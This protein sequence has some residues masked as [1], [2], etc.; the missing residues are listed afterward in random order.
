MK[1]EADSSK[2]ARCKASRNPFERFKKDWYDQWK[3]I[4]RM[5]FHQHNN[6]SVDT[7]YY[8]VEKCSLSNMRT[9]QNS[10]TK[11]YRLK[12]PPQKFPLK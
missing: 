7:S 12:W 5:S 3:D 1:I 6:R 4:A 2:I 11:R 10:D 9:T 8:A